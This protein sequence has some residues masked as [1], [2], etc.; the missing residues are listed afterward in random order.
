MN[1]RC[2]VLFAVLFGACS[3]PSEPT[4]APIESAEAFELTEWPV[5]QDGS[6]YPDYPVATPSVVT[7]ERIEYEAGQLL[8]VR[9]N[10]R[11]AFHRAGEI[12]TYPPEHPGYPD[13]FTD[14][15]ARR[16]P[17]NEFGE[18]FP[19]YAWFPS[20]RSMSVCFQ[21]GEPC[22][23][24]WK[25]VPYRYHSD[26]YHT[27]GQRGQY[28]GIYLDGFFGELAPTSEPST[29]HLFECTDTRED[30]RLFRFGGVWVSCSDGVG[31]QIHFLPT[32][33]MHERY[34]CFL[35]AMVDWVAQFE[36]LRPT[37]SPDALRSR[38]ECPEDLDGSFQALPEV[39]VVTWVGFETPITNAHHHGYSFKSHV[40]DFPI[41]HATRGRA[42]PVYGPVHWPNGLQYSDRFGGR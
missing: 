35:R 23:V 13:S 24:G 25:P 6:L 18:I 22:D 19:S 12:A 42:D 41:Q 38:F 39:E 36:S 20:E 4:S 8:W 2:V 29:L 11:V 37:I 34:M 15:L 28:S 26:F 17:P 1:H 31:L 9:P 10:H 5:L 40:R 30:V 7:P 21:D 27:G 14:R 32:T 33:A 3:T 16:G